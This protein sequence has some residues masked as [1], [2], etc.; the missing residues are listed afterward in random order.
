MD[1]DSE[2]ET[3]FYGKITF[4]ADTLVPTKT[5]LNQLAL[6][7]QQSKS[8]RQSKQLHLNTNLNP[9]AN[10]NPRLAIANS[11]LN[12]I[13][14]PKT[15]PAVAGASEFNAIYNDLSVLKGVF[16]KFKPFSGCNVNGQTVT[17]GCAYISAFESY[18]IKVY[19]DPA[20][21]I[22]HFFAFIDNSLFKWFFGLA[23]KDKMKF[24]EFKK[25]FVSEVQRIEYESYELIDAKKGE[26]LRK[27]KEVKSDSKFNQYADRHKNYVFFREKCILVNLVYPKLHSGD[28]VRFVLSKLDTKEEFVKYM[29]YEKD[30]DALIY[31]LK[32]EDCSN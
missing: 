3:D 14:Q 4:N 15:G 32:L 23:D 13:V 16:G 26:F 19:P 18:L 31:F 21:I 11:A 2:E 7:S 24:E 22:P 5:S 17:D 29:Q 12:G 6:A 20:A 28:L 8:T 9:S 10:K 27:L 25:S 1:T 30:V